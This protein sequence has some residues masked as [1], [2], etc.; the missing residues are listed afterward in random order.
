VREKLSLLYF[1]N[2]AVCLLIALPGST[3]NNFTNVITGDFWIF[4]TFKLWRTKLGI[5]GTLLE[6]GIHRIS[7]RIPDT[8]NSYLPV[9]GEPNNRHHNNKI[10]IR[11]L[12]LIFCIKN[13]TFK[14]WERKHSQ[15]WPFEIAGILYFTSN[16][17][18]EQNI[19]PDI[20]YPAFRLAGYPA[21][22]VSGASLIE[23]YLIRINF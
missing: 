3:W 21:K 23:A 2:L 15:I 19:R 1:Y 4:N 20:W 17:Y 13:S 7:G 22:P 14:V 11:I 8:S 10:F 16:L 6:L 12:Q 18:I 9:A 5:A